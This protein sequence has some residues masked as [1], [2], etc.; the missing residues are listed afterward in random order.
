M[1]RRAKRAREERDEELEGQALEQANARKRFA[2]ELEKREKEGSSAR[3]ELQRAQASLTAQMRKWHEERLARKREQL[4]KQ[5]PTAAAAAEAAATAAGTAPK[6]TASEPAESGTKGQ[7][8]PVDPETIGLLHKSLEV[9]WSSQ[10]VQH[11]ADSLRKVFEKFG[12]VVHVS[13]RGK[14]RT[15]S[16]CLLYT[17][18]SPRDRTRSRMPSSA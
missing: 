2:Q 9:R 1:E 5:A 16:T 13:M 6:G 8:K 7:A 11:D 15:A 17:S 14:R 18:P 4:R 10:H 12:D 3:T